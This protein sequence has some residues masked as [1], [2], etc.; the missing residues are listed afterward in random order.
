MIFPPGEGLHGVYDSKKLTPLQRSRLAAQIKGAAL[1]WSVVAVEP[2]EID[3]LNIL[4][5]A[6]VAMRR[7]SR[8]ARSGPR[9]TCWSTD[10]IAIVGL[11]CTQEPMIKGDS[12]CHAIAAASILAK[13]TRDELMVDLDRRYPGYGF[14]DHKGYPTG[15]HRDAIRKLGPTPVHRKS[16]TLLPHPRLFD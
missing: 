15:E 10:A 8:P 6:L 1:T 4:R 14:A 13:T 5:A 2:T 12:R 3:Q 16:F 7:A 9:S 11:P